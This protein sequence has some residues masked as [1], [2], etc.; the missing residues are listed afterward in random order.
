ME[1]LY[2]TASDIG[3]DTVKANI[4]N[5]DITIP[6]IIG[7]ANNNEKIS[8]L[9]KT[10][11]DH[12]M[13]DFF[14][15][16][17]A[18]VISDSVKTTGPLFVG[19]AAINNR[20]APRR[21]DINNFSFK[22][23]DDLS[24]ILNLVVLAAKRVKDAYFKQEDLSQL[25]MDVYLTTAL[26]IRE[27]KQ[28]GILSDYQDRYLKTKH[29]VTFNNFKDPITVTLNFK[30]VLVVLE[31]TTAQ[32]ALT[33][34]AKQYP[35]L[36]NSILND[37]KKQYHLDQ[38]KLEDIVG[39][40]NSIG[41]DIGG[42]TVDFSVVMNGRTNTNVS[43]SSLKGYDS[44]LQA[45]ITDLQNHMRNFSDI[46]QLE[47]Y[48]QQGPNPFD[49]TSYQQ[50]LD[51]VKENS[52]NLVQSIVASV[53][54]IMGQSSLNPDVVF[55]YGGGSVPLARDTDLRQQLSQK[56]RSFNGD[57]KIPIIWI[58]AKYAQSLNKLGLKLYL[59]F[60]TGKKLQ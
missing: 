26:P 48:L 13:N 37:F 34:A 29:V 35:E 23:K 17:E 57:R 55:V 45:S 52:K 12:Y 11:K 56:L 24:L 15:H 22:S 41:I 33:N 3:N 54:K 19:Q 51:I 50:V 28:R 44:V 25:T 30:A 16:L 18:T 9:D 53:S 49:P 14:D 40:K 39:Q 2:M 21:F 36:A 4:N 46:G 43:D 6:S 27:G 47:S 1:N 38:I 7:D 42:K 5:E 8:F 10:E 20:V 59:K 60:L 58:N 32:I 31:G